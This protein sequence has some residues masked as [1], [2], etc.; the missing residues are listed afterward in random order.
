MG[1][2]VLRLLLQCE[3]RIGEQAR[4]A[5]RGTHLTVEDAERRRDVLPLPLPNS[6]YYIEKLFQYLNDPM[7]H[8]E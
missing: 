8:P 5:L 7:G 3:S 6:G 4:A 2:Q 1:V